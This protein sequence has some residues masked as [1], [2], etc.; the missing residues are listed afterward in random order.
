MKTQRSIHPV[1]VGDSILDNA[2]YTDGGPDVRTQLQALSGG[3]VTL[4]AVDGSIVSDVADQLEAIPPGATHVVLSVGGNDAVGFSHVLEAECATVGQ[5]LDAL[6]D[7]IEPFEASYRDCLEHVVALGLPTVV[8]T[9]YNGAFPEPAGR[10]VRA[11]LRMV[12]DSIFQAAFDHGVPVIDLRRVCT[13]PEDYYDPIEPNAVGG[14]K[15][16]SAIHE[17]LY[18]RVRTRSSWICPSES[19]HHTERPEG[20]RGGI[21]S[22]LQPQYRGPGH[23]G[24]GAS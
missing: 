24:A 8:C 23:R 20:S 12:N 14:A 15:I 4:L 17:V 9:I 13:E 2:A 21:M 22:I 19:G 16:A 5:A 10:W 18:E 7:Q 11:A 6:M 1:L 3:P